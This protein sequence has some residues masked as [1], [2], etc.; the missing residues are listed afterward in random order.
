MFFERQPMT[1]AGACPIM[2]RVERRK[3]EKVTYILEDAASRKLPT[4]EKFNLKNIIDS[5]NLSQLEKVDTIVKSSLTFAELQT[6]KKEPQK[7]PQK[8]EVN[9]A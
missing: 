3:G 6:D 8:Q 2:E 7:E 4:P 1:F 9:N 5:G